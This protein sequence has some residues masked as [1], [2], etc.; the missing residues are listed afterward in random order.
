MTSARHW[1]AASGIALLIL[2]AILIA[3]AGDRS[4][5]RCEDGGGTYI[6]HTVGKTY[7]T[8]CLEP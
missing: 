7:W 4:Q 3:I 5:R 2:F 1:L 8:Q 6:I